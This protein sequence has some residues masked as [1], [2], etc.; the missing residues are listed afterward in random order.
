MKRN[1]GHS[2]PA[3]RW[4]AGLALVASGSVVAVTGGGSAAAT[5]EAVNGHFS[6]MSSSSPDCASPFGVCMTGTVSGRIKGSF[7]FTARSLIATDDTP[8][9]GA[10]VTTGDATVETKSGTILCKLTGT[11]QVNDEGP[12]VSL[13]VVTGGTGGW[14]GVTG[15]LRTSGTFTLDGGGSGSYD[16][17]IVGQ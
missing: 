7:S 9:T 1:H 3:R 4:I 6:L 16:G 8:T 2:R 11:L 10:I 5:P 13:C 15:Y 12:F 17:N 14:A